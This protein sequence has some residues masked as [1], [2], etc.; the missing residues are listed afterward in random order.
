MAPYYLFREKGRFGALLTKQVFGF[1][2][3]GPLSA[4]VIGHFKPILE[5]EAPKFKQVI[6]QPLLS[7]RHRN[8]DRSVILPVHSL[9]NSNLFGLRLDEQ[10]LYN[11][12]GDLEIESVLEKC[13]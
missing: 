6:S 2:V 7:Q 13:L 8:R 12:V 3:L 9:V 11:T 5:T 10:L 1:S 4:L